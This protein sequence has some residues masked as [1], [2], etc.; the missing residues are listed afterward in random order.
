MSHWTIDN[1][2][3]L[4]QLDIFNDFKDIVFNDEDI[5]L[6]ETNKEKR[7]P[8]RTLSLDNNSSVVCNKTSEV[9][10]LSNT[11]EFQPLDVGEAEKQSG[12]IKSASILN[13]P[14]AQFT[15]VDY[16]QVDEIIKEHKEDKFHIDLTDLFVD[17][18]APSSTE[19]T[20]IR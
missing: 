18:P 3:F 9:F 5:S 8:F 14:P 17:A 19:P 10:Y 4:S 16:D 1:W 15:V 7:N 13:I 20:E 6:F 12:E 2:F 11:F